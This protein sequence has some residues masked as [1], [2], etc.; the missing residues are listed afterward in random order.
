[1]F[2]PDL[3]SREFK[4]LLEGV[5]ARTFWGEKIMLAVVDL[6]ANAIVPE[7]THPHEQA[8]IV[9]A[10][11]PEFII[12]GEKRQLKP[13][14]LYLI[15]GGTPHSVIVGSIPAQVLDIFSPV[16]EEFKY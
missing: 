5:Q 11:E 13:G 15:P 9:L 1:M 10:G 7:H 12:A 6:A 8:G 14:D 4:K 3:T 16:R 2:Y